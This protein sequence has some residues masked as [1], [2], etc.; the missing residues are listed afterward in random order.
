MFFKKQKSRKDICLS[1][2]TMIVLEIVNKVLKFVFQDKVPKIIHAD[3]KFLDPDKELVPFTKKEH[4]YIMTKVL[5]DHPF[6]YMN[7]EI[8][9]PIQSDGGHSWEMVTHSSVGVKLKEIG[10]NFW[11]SCRENG[12]LA[13]NSFDIAKEKMQKTLQNVRLYFQAMEEMAKNPFGTV[14]PTPQTIRLGQ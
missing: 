7:F 14:A 10:Q 1:N 5:L 2:S 4:Q 9:F 13:W 8:V 12:S 6:A 11:L 3:F